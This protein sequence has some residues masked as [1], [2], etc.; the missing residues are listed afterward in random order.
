VLY[1]SETH[2]IIGA[3]FDDF[4]SL[5]RDEWLPAVAKDRGTRFLWYFNRAHGSSVSFNV[6]TVTAA[7]DFEAWAR[8]QDRV[9]SGDMQELAHTADQM[10]YGTSAA[11]NRRLEWSRMPEVDLTSVPTT[12]QDHER[13]MYIEDTIH[14]SLDDPDAGEAAIRKAHRGLGEPGPGALTEFVAAFRPLPVAGRRSQVTLLQRVL[15]LGILAKYY[16]EGTP[17]PNPPWSAAHD[18]VP[19]DD[20]WQT[21]V[22]RVATWSPLA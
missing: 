16:T 3:R 19:F 21:R 7:A 5:C 20:T 8:L 6:V 2:R 18:P 17:P 15:D 1:I 4:E 12:A 9:E 22:L 13:T 10:R 11:I 14:V